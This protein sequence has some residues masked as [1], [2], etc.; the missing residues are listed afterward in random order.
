MGHSRAEIYDKFYI[1]QVVGTD[2]QSAYLG[3]PSK[4]ALINLIGH[5]I[6]ALSSVQ[7]N[8]KAVK[9]DPEVQRLEDQRAQL[10]ADI[11]AEFGSIKAATGMELHDKCCTTLAD[12]RSRKEQVRRL[13][14]DKD[15][16]SHFKY[17][18]TRYI[19]EQRRG[20]TSTYT[21]VTPTF[22]FHERDQLAGLLC[23]NRD[24]TEM[25]EHE[26]YENRPNALRNTISLC[27]RILVLT[28]M[29]QF[30]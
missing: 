26:V 14:L 12:L 3:T 13:T 6:L 21:E 25:S 29:E 30:H 15:W 8:Q 10:R 16:E 9:L 27:E 22:I 4:D 18:S 7:P 5:M 11:V 1:N 23:Q 28:D 19:D 17:S 24:I 2:T 20:I